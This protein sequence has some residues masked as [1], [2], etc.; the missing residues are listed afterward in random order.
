MI[1]FSSDWH[2]GHKNI[3]AGVSSWTNKE[4]N[5][6]NF[7]TIEDMNR[8]IVESINN[9]VGQDDELYFLGDLFFGGIEN[10][11][12]I[13]SQLICKN[14]HVILG[15]HDKHIRNNKVLPNCHRENGVIVDGPNKTGISDNDVSA[16]ELFLS[17]TRDAIIS[18]NKLSFHLYHHPIEDWENMN[19]GGIH[20]HGHVHNKFDNHELNTKYRRMD[21]C[22]KDG[23]IY[24]IEEV[25][26]L[27]MKRE[28]KTHH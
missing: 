23:K 6:R 19:D 9:T 15:N 21:V 24:S 25:Y 28:I 1:F 27:M 20:L 3:C 26:N 18:Y 2:F 22:W 14:I 7:N 4:I 16:R 10:L 5:C 12:K 11:W 8:A 17:V 13:I